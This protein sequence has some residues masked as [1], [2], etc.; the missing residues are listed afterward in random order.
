[1]DIFF[2]PAFSLMTSS[3]RSQPVEGNECGRKKKAATHLQAMERRKNGDQEKAVA[4]TESGSF[5]AAV[6]KNKSHLIIIIAVNDTCHFHQFSGKL[7]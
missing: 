4:Q 7:P 3:T 2:N 5:S 1:M 6:L